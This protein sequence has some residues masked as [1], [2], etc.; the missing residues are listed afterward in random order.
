VI[1]DNHNLGYDAFNKMCAGINEITKK[2]MKG[3]SPNQIHCMVD[4]GDLILI[5]D[6]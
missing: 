2:M 5:F 3:R 6:L 1:L 4:I